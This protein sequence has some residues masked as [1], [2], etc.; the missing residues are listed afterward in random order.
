MGIYFEVRVVY[1]VEYFNLDCM[2]VW[3]V[4]RWKIGGNKYRYGKDFSFEGVVVEDR[5]LF[6]IIGIKFIWN[7]GLVNILIFV[8][9][10]WFDLIGL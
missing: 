3:S 9:L 7:V 8:F 5:G 10:F 4:L 6:Y 1:E 2:F